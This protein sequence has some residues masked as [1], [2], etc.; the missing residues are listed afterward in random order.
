MTH[1]KEEEEKKIKI[2]DNTISEVKTIHSSRVRPDHTCKS[3]AIAFPS[4]L[5]VEETD[6]LPIFFFENKT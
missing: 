6:P 3:S 1:Q 2:D 4:Q 5:V